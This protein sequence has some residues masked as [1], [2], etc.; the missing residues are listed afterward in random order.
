VH[1]VSR[2]CSAA[3]GGQILC[4]GSVAEA[5]GP[6][7]AEAV[8][9]NLGGYLLRGL[10]EA[11]WLYQVSAADLEDDFPPPREAVRDGGVRMTIWQREAPR[12]VR[13]S[14]PPPAELEV[15]AVDGTP[16]C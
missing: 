6:T 5:L 8:L 9:R 2:L 4:S 15:T 10:P 14:A 3:H 7:P 13:S 1:E 11:R 16:I 12:T